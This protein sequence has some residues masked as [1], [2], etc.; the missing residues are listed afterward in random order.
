MHNIQAIL[1]SRRWERRYFVLLRAGE[2]YLYKTRQEYRSRPKEPIYLRPLQLHDFY[3]RIDNADEIARADQDEDML[4]MRAST[5]TPYSGGSDKGHST[6]SSNVSQKVPLYRFQLTLIPRE[7]LDEAVLDGRK[8]RLRNHWLLRCDTEEELDIW[9][10]AI[11]ETC[12]S[13]MK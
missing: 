4:T 2:F 7:N 11:K 12:P 1:E 5:L 8:A 9:V 6:V 10:A 3:V 13:C